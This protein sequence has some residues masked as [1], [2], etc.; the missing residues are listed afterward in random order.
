MLGAI[1]VELLG[2]GTAGGAD[3]ASTREA[4]DA[5]IDWHISFA[6]ANKA[7]IIVQDRDWASLPSEARE[8]V[9]TLQRQYVDLWATQLRGIDSGLAKK[10]ALARAHATF[11]MLNSTPH[12]AFLPRSQMRAM[13]HEMAARAVGLEAAP[14]PR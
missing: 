5:L 1:R 9:R 10:E 4:I 7:L 6:L 12:S 11:G 13:L 8:R 14:H 3:A 2:G